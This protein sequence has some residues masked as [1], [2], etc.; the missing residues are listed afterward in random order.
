MEP[1]DLSAG[2]TPQQHLPDYYT[3]VP[4]VTTPPKD[5]KVPAATTPLSPETHEEGSVIQHEF[6]WLQ[7]VHCHCKDAPTKDLNLS[8]AAFHANSH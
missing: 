3:K 2:K 4:P 6:D 1:I 7:Y 8:W 5:I